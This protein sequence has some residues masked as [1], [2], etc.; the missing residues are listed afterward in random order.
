MIK[1]SLIDIMG[2]PIAHAVISYK[3]NGAE[4]N[5]TTNDLGIF[6]IQATGSVQMTY[7]GNGTLL[8]SD[9]SVSLNDETPVVKDVVIDAPNITRS[10]I[11]AAAGEK[12]DMY[13]FTLKDRQ[14]NVL[15]N[16]NVQVRLN[17]VLYTVI[18]DGEGKAGVIIPFSVANTYDLSIFFPGDE[19][20][21]SASAAVKV[22]IT[23]KPTNIA[24]KNKYA[25]K[26]KAKSK[27]IK[28][29]LKTTNSYLNAGKK[30]TLKIKGKTYTANIGKN[31]KIKLKIKLTKIGTYS[32]KIKFAGD[33]T[34]SPTTSKKII[35]AAC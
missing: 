22:T 20:Y 27:V 23:K 13:Y 29:T 30:V 16:K 33:S 15:V 34:Y 8:A 12:G 10:A 26:A 3:V 31:G 21:K 1:G 2:N 32:G 25:F 28:A 35:L 4:S 6:E 5:V 14:G 17:N 24:A 9:A 7:A 18:T 11:D 19:N